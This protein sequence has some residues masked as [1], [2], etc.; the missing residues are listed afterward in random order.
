MQPRKHIA[1]IIIFILIFGLQTKLGFSRN[2]IESL[3]VKAIPAEILDTICPLY[4]TFQMQIIAGVKMYKTE[5]LTIKY[6]LIGDNGFASNWRQYNIAKGDTRT[7]VFRRRIDPHAIAEKTDIKNNPTLELKGDK[8]HY[9]GWSAVELIYQ[10][11]LRKIYTVGSN[12]AEF[13]IECK[14]LEI[15]N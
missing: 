11:E 12:K 7:D 10:D 14:E 8:I 15:I 3:K 6:R 13:N 5:Q 1:I 2:Y 4:L 9:R